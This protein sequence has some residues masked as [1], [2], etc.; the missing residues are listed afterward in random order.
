MAQVMLYIT[1]YPAEESIYML[2]TH[3]KSK[4]DPHM[5]LYI[6]HPIVLLHRDLY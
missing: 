3:R 4:S 6:A 5:T 1:Q 2:S